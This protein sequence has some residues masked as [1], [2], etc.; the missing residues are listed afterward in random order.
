MTIELGYLH[1]QTYIL[2]NPW[3]GFAVQFADTEKPLMKC[4]NITISFMH[5]GFHLGLNHNKF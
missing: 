4:W 3:Y 5:F 1:L 2:K